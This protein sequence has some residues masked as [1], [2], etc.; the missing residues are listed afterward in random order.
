MT[1][2]EESKGRPA[3]RPNEGNQPV[4]RTNNEATP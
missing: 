2:V 1:G 4:A 3:G